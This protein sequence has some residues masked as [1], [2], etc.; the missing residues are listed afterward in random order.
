[1]G[2][3]PVTTVEWI[4]FEATIIVIALVLIAIALSFRKGSY[5]KIKI[6][7]LLP[8]AGFK[9][10]LQQV[11]TI[12]THDGLFPSLT[13]HETYFEYRLV[14]GHKVKYSDITGIE[15]K[16]YLLYGHTLLLKVKGKSWGFYPRDL[17]LS[18]GRE[19]NLK[20]LEKFFIEKTKK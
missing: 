20:E 16:K 7:K 4:L 17:W 2:K 18:M 3:M 9:F 12:L 13:L 5:P 14:N 19:D 10:K 15:T 11:A 8:R 6:P 1:M